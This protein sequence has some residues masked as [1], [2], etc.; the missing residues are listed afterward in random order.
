MGVR[1]MDYKSIGKK[2]AD[3][4]IL[5]GI[6]QEELAEKLDTSAN[7]ISNIETGIKSGSLVFYLKIANELK[8]SLDYLFSEEIPN[9]DVT[10]ANNKEL[11]E[12]IDMLSKDE[13]QMANVFI[14]NIVKSL[15]ELR[16]E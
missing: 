16:N 7:Y 1:N 4:R 15:I 2:I 12:L 6:T 9:V 3:K 8:L 13:K 10:K 5:L 11:I 14:R